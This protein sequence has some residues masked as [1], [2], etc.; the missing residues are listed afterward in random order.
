MKKIFVFTAILSGIAFACKNKQK[1]ETI[2]QQGKENFF[3]VYQFL[4]SEIQY[5]DSLPIGIAKYATYNN[6]TDTFYIKMPEF[7]KIA[8]GFLCNELKPE[9]FEKEFSESAFMD[10]TTHSATFT[11]A[12]QNPELELQRV[13][14]LAKTNES[15]NNVSS[16]YLEKTK[17]SSDT[18]IQQKLLW[19]TRTSCEIITSEQAPGKKPVISQTKLV[20][21]IE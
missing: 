5:V 12:A 15:T 21:G 16:V 19:R 9:I 8:G 17:H 13:D 11:Y 14:V 1:K 10:Q 2:R 6:K 20:W 7:D 18:L 4:Q 3:H